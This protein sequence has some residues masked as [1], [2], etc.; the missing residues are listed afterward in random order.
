MSMAPFGA[1]PVSPQSERRRTRLAL[2]IASVGIAATLLA[3]AV[4]PGVRHAVSHA[5]HSV[6]HAVGNVIDH[7]TS[8]HARKPA[9]PAKH[10]PAPTGAPSHP[11]TQAPAN[12][13]SPGQTTRTS[14]AGAQG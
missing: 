6:K 8:K 3:Y 10:S 14:P 1:R 7:D 12:Q 2:M 13:R 11:A 9:S 5:A 4:S